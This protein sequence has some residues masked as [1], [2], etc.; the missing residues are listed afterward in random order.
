MAARKTNG[1]KGLQENQK[2]DAVVAT[3]QMMRIGLAALSE[4][5]RVLENAVASIGLEE[6]QKKGLFSWL[7]SKRR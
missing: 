1:S 7:T 4:R 2:T 5:V 3:E 6:T